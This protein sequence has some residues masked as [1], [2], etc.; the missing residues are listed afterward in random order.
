MRE[1]AESATVPKMARETT[2][3]RDVEVPTSK[4]ADETSTLPT[5]KKIEESLR[6]GDLVLGDTDIAS[7]LPMETQKDVEGPFTASPSRSRSPQPSPERSMMLATEMVM[8]LHCEL[9][10]L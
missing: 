3:Q 4:V 8:E 2:I 10:N 6:S 9:P 7:T 5:L 1:V